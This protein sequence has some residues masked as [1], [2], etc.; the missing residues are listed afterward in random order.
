M[1]WWLKTDQRLMHKI[2]LTTNFWYVV[3]RHSF[4]DW[5]VCKKKSCS[6]SRQGNW[7][8]SQEITRTRMVTFRNKISYISWRL[9]LLFQPNTGEALR[10]LLFNV[11]QIRLQLPNETYNFMDIVGTKLF[12]LQI[13]QFDCL[14]PTWV[15]GTQLAAW[16]RGWH[17][18]W[19][20]YNFSGQCFVFF[21]LFLAYLIFSLSFLSGQ[22]CLFLFVVFFRPIFSSSSFLANVLKRSTLATSRLI[23]KP[24]VAILSH[25]PKLDTSYLFLQWTGM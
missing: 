22:C 6:T 16:C 21:L 7:L 18:T 15:L 17:R 20:H 9:L 13:W 19:N 23:T 24:D 5:L 10:Q 12:S 8:T 4:A 1:I 11:D 25:S 3:E 2:W 14:A